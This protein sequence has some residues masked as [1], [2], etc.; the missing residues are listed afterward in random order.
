MPERRHDSFI[1]RPTD[2]VELGYNNIGLYR[3]PTNTV[4]PGYNNIGLYRRPTN[5]VEPGYTASV[6]TEDPQI[7]WNP[8]IQHRFIQ[9]THKYSGTRLYNI[10]LYDSSTITSDILW[11]QLFPHW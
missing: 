8:V 4:E 11:Y 2:T 5:T 3:R 7:Q 6:Y 10:G 9:K 1:R